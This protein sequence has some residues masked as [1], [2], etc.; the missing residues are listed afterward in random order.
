M[1]ARTD[2]RYFCEI[3]DVVLRFSAMEMSSED[4][5]GIHGHDERISEKQLFQV[6][7]FYQ[8]MIGKS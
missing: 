4:R 3:S 2:S 8:R 6:I 7:E 5:K 1:L